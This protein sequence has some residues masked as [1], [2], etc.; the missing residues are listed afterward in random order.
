M[1]CRDKKG[2]TVR[3][4][5]NFINHR[6][7]DLDLFGGDLKPCYTVGRAGTESN[8]TERQADTTLRYSLAKENKVN[9][10]IDKQ[11][12]RGR[13]LSDFNNKNKHAEGCDSTCF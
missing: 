1:A 9:R 5:D 13:S 3:R 2:H 10:N 12:H 7:L 6:G 4:R 11:L 8:H